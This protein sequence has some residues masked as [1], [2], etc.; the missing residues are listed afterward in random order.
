MSAM[1]PVR[2][3][4]RSISSTSRSVG[5]CPGHTAYACE[6]A[7]ELRASVQPRR[8]RA[9]ICELRMHT[10]HDKRDLVHV[11]TCTMYDHGDSIMVYNAWKDW[12]RNH[13]QSSTQTVPCGQPRAGQSCRVQSVP[14]VGTPCY[15]TGPVQVRN[16]S[17]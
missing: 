9:D 8:A 15:Q 7:R 1:T 16:S 10:K 3:A 6:R 13:A 4:V 14:G 17:V 2:S 11:L 5:K 12:R